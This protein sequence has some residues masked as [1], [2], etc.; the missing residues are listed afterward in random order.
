MTDGE[1]PDGT[2]FAGGDRAANRRGDAVFSGL[3]LAAGITVLVII[4]AITVFLVLR[5]VPALV[6]NS[7][8]FLTETD[9]FPNNTPPYFG[10]AAIAFGT[11]LTSAIALLL[12]VPVSVGVALFI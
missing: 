3:S 8:S 7:A 12:G 4:A 6:D 5:A 9:W 10:I 1:R 2:P 11:V